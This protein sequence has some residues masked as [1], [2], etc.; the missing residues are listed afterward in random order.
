MHIAYARI[1][2]DRNTK[3][4]CEKSSLSLLETLFEI[5]FIHYHSHADV[6][7]VGTF[8][9]LERVINRCSK[10][11]ARFRYPET[12]NEPDLDDLPHS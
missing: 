11:L 6:A 12:A 7:I 2:V 4:S 8:D 3:V 9:Q 10:S 5:H 1:I